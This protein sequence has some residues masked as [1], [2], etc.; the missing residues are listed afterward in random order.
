MRI[1][2]D[3]RHDHL[4]MAIRLARSKHGMSNVDLYRIERHGSRKRDRAFD[5]NLQG[6]G[7]RHT[8]K[9]NSGTRGAGSYYAATW[10][11]WGWF[12]LELFEL[13]PEAIAGP[14]DGIADFHAQ[15]QGRFELDTA[16]SASRQHYID[17]G[18]YLTTYET[19]TGLDRSKR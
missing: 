17:T 1:H 5:V 14:Y 10:D 15:T 12:L 6:Y 4:P 19:R 13:D 9:T 3:L 16:D 7:D 2:T 8:R 11:D 18:R